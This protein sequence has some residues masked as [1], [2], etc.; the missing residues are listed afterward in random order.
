M[1]YRSLRPTESGYRDL[2]IDGQTGFLLKTVWSSEV[3][4]SVSQF[5]PL[6][7]PFEIAHHLAQCTVFEGDALAKAITHLISN[8]TVAEEMGQA[9][10][11]RVAEHFCWT[12]IARQY[13]DLWTESG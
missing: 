11:R 5:A 1:Q 3:A 7:N 8:P 6:M 13:L 2:I 9:A 12:R 4:K 10:R